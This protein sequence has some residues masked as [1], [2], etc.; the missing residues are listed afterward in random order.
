M[1]LSCF[2]M[3]LQ[4]ETNQ[5]HIKDHNK[6]NLNLCCEHIFNQRCIIFVSAVDFT[7]QGKGLTLA[8]SKDEVV[9][10]LGNEKC[11]VKTLDDTHLY[12]EPPE[13]QPLGSDH[14]TLPSLKVSAL[15]LHTI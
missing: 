12:C 8:V 7:V 4:L 13:E 9:A 3:I 5:D 6:S 2:N 15:D 10:L 14:E 1:F 11:D